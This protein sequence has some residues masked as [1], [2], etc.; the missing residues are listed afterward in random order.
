MN[1]EFG[2]MKRERKVATC[3]PMPWVN[4]P[5]IQN[6]LFPRVGSSS[7]GEELL[8]FKSHDGSQYLHRK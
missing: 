4:T 7:Y 2:I 3:L 1:Y 8:Y 6:R 5:T